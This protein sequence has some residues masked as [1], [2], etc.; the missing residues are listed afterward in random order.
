MT[1]GPN[2]SFELTLQ[3][4]L[5][6]QISEAQF[7]EHLKDPLFA[8]WFNQKT[9]KLLIGGKS[10]T[11]AGL[12]VVQRVQSDV[13]M[14]YV[15]VVEGTE[16]ERGWGQRPNG[17]IAFKTKNDALSFIDRYNARFNSDSN[18]PNEYTVYTYIGVKECSAEIYNSFK[19][20][21]HFRKWDEL[22][23]DKANRCS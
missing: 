23:N 9:I 12:N 18:V 15:H 5:S 6:G 11:N 14:H 17:F 8:S 13:S 22:K 4:F 19:S 3:C 21:L 16:Y 1:P 7:Q 10:S 20:V 2:Y